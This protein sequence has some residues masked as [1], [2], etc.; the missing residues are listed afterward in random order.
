MLGIV[1]LK[2]FVIIDFFLV[3]IFEIKDPLIE[4][5]LNISNVQP[6]IFSFLLP[7]PILSYSLR[8]SPKSIPIFYQIPCLSNKEVTLRQLRTPK[9][10]IKDCNLLPILR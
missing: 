9:R 2:G 3:T 4:V 5:T 6:D 1:I 7:H 10:L 8:T